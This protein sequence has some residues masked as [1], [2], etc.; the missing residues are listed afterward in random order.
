MYDKFANQIAVTG[1][2][3]P[4][5]VQVVCVAVNNQQP[6]RDYD[7][8]VT[9]SHKQKTDMQVGSTDPVG[10]VI[11]A[12]NGGSAIKETLNGTAII[13]YENG[14]YLPAQEREQADQ[15]LQQSGTLSST[16]SPR[17]RISA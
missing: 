3:Y 7:L 8:N 4:T 16:I 5:G 1:Q 11:H 2:Q 12:D 6:P 14:P 10:D 15:L 17:R 9:T 13:H